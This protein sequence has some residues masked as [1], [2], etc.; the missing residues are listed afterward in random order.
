M[1]AKATELS[2]LYA[3]EA[4]TFRT[5]LQSLADEEMQR[6]LAQAQG[7]HDVEVQRICHSSS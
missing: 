5:L 7:Q 6:V 3:S 1:D 2:N 4:E